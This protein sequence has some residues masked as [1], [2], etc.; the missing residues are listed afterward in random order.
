MS[1]N[2]FT[3]DE[4]I[5]KIRSQNHWDILVIGGGATGASIALDAATRGLSVALIE[6][7]DFG[8]GTSSRSTKL[9]HGGVRY[10]A[11]GN[12]SLVREA[13]HE[14]TR[15]RNNAPHVVHELSFL[16]PCANRLQ[17]IWYSLG[18]FVYD[19]LAG[20]SGFTRAKRF[21]AAE[22]L[23]SVPTIA[24]EQAKYG[25]L[26]SD[27]QFDD[28]RLLLNILQ[29]ASESGATVCNYVRATDFIKNTQGKITGV[30]ATDVESASDTTFPIQATC[31]INATG[32]FC[33]ELRSKDSRSNKPM[34]AP[35]QGVH[36]VLSKSFLPGN[37]AVIVP[38]TSDGRVIF[39]I[40]WHDHT[41]VGTTD[42]PIDRPVDE[43]DARREEINF[44]L[45][46]SGDYLSKKPTDAD[47]LSVFTGIRPLVRSGA[48]GNTS[49]LSRDHTIEIASSG[50]V[51]ITGGKWTTARRMAEDC[52]NQVQN[53][54]PNVGACAT[55]NLALH[56]SDHDL[57]D[58]LLAQ[59]PTLA[60]QLVPQYAIRDVDVV[61]AARHEMARSVEDVLARRTR[62]L[63]LNAR[64]A[65]IAAPRVAQ[66]LAREL[67]KDDRWVAE[68]L[69][70][71]NET[72]SHF[73]PPSN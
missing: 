70:L 53:H 62:L 3:R 64:A 58:N 51:T 6:R 55:K 12:I 4:S 29:S 36:I 18:F 69:Q 66:L 46:T 30:I 32:A 43:P 45:K 20:K 28:T 21:N 63:F 60:Q 47:I 1:P 26:Y 57:I 39:M 15:L 17:Q 50:L 16:V 49:K 40:P 33:D 52:V 31:V 65:N 59:D 23:V 7:D 10:L 44:L 37:C 72:A 38:K 25:I 8:K 42:T 71:F 9:V 13:L 27:G 61:F 67:K 56:G 11:Q 41:V 2:S 68:Q 34:I 22:C 48:V 14:R 54:F 73:L 19:W 35:S 5:R 24:R